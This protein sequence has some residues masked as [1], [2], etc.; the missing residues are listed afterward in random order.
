MEEDDPKY[1]SIDAYNLINDIGEVFHCFEPATVHNFIAQ[2]VEKVVLHKEFIE[3]KL[4]PYGATLYENQGINKDDA[5]CKKTITLKYAV[6][7]G[8]KRGS[9]KIEEP[10]LKSREIPI[11]DEKLY[12]AVTQAFYYKELMETKEL[13]LADISR[14]E[15]CDHSYLGQ[16]VRLTTL[17]PDII[18]AIIEGR[19][20][21]LLTLRRLLR[22][23]FP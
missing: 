23:R 11:R 14:R 8:R 2:I 3:I 9:V 10:E 15:H 13:S 20:P 21:K 6:T 12:N 22:E 4:K 1:T 16:I 5:Y 7:F 18:M 19:Q 17:A